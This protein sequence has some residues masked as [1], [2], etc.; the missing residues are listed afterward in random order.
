[1]G[2]QKGNEAR[3]EIQVTAFKIYYRR[4]GKAKL[5]FDRVPGETEADA[6]RW[7]K[8]A[9]RKV[10]WREVEVVR[11]ESI[12]PWEVADGVLWGQVWEQQS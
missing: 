6:M 11:V 4:A 7:F 12:D 10:G 9:A 1:M 8:A 5:Q 2:G 3:R